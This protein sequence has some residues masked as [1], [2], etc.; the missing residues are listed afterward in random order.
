MSENRENTRYSCFMGLPHNTLDETNMC[1]VYKTGIVW[2][3]IH[4]LGLW[5]FKI[6]G[7]LYKKD[8]AFGR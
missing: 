8:K 6:W 3:A 7:I 4:N 2:Y 1:S 5:G